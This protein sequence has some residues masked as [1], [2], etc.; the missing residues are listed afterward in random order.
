VE[1]KVLNADVL[2]IGGGPAGL[3]AAIR[4]RDLGARV[5][6]VDKANTMQSGS[7]AK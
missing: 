7:V 2:C 3:M 4:A 1:E 6:V 5:I